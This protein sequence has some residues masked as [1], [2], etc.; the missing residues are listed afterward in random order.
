MSKYVISS[1]T[2]VEIFLLFYLM[3]LE[4]T[5]ENYVP[6]FRLRKHQKA[7]IKKMMCL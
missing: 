6:V 7:T 4:I 3:A 2:E 1:S 5:F